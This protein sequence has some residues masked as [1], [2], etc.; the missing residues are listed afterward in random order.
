MKKIYLILFFIIVLV[1]SSKAQ[2]VIWIEGFETSDSANLPTG[3]TNYNNSPKDTI[4]PYWNW[5]VRPAGLNLPGLST[6]LS[7]VHTG[8]KSVGVSWWTGVSSGISDAWLVTQRIPNVPSDGLFSFWVTGG[9][10]SFSDSVQIWISTGDSTP[11]SFLSNPA[12]YLQNIFFPVGSVYGNFVQYYIDLAPYAG[13]NVYMGFRYNMNMAVDG[14][15]VQL[16][17]VQLEGT[18]GISQ[19]G[20]NVPDKFSLS[21]N[22]PNPFNPTTKINFDLAKSTNVKLTIF[23]SLG[24]VVMNIF[25][26]YKPSG[27]Y[28]AEFNGGSLSSGTYYYRL[29]T[30]FY[31]ETKKMQLIK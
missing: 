13:Q 10:A 6:R 28:Q 5:T 18:V 2:G 15:Y 1:N 8:E 12:N 24:Q 3:W 26:G 20:I 30:D 25:E 14:Y 21:Q 19:N 11:A 7:V 31:T 4:E 9:S 22:Y 17:D 16:D 29:D 27:S 23:N